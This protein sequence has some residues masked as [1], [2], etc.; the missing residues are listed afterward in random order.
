MKPIILE[1]NAMQVVKG[2]NSMEQNWSW[3]GHLVAEMRTILHSL[4]P[5]RCC[6]VSRNGNTTTR[7]LAKLAVHHVT[8]FTWREEIPNCIHDVILLEQSLELIS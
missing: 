2:V 6:H 5:W 4:A 1:G 3:F 8:D 7:F